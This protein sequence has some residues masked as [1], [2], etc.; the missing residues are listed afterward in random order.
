MWHSAFT[1]SWPASDKAFSFIPVCLPS[2][3]SISKAILAGCILLKVLNQNGKAN[4][5]E[6]TE[7]RESLEALND[8]DGKF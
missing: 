7:R 5:V 1:F 3:G 4:T 2:L 6:G 8:S